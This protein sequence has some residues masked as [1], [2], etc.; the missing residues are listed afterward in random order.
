MTIFLPMLH[1]I[2]F[3]V[4]GAV[5]A[6]GFFRGPRSPRPLDV[7]LGQFG[8]FFG[9]FAACNPVRPTIGLSVLLP[10][11]CYLSILSNIPLVFHLSVCLKICLSFCRLVA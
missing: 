8:I 2:N 10:V 6:L 3:F 4:G 5:F 9:R 7:P 11:C 1:T